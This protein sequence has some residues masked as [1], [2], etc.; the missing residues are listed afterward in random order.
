[1]ATRSTINPRGTSG[2][3]S[4]AGFLTFP[5]GDERRPAERRAPGLVPPSGHCARPFT[6][7][8][9]GGAGGSGRRRPMTCCAASSTSNI[10]STP[11]NRLFLNPKGGQR[12][13]PVPPAAAFGVWGGADA[14][15]QFAVE[16]CGAS[17]GCS[18]SSS[19]RST[20]GNPMGRPS[21][22]NDEK[23]WARG[24]GHESA[25]FLRTQWRQRRDDGPHRGRGVH[26]RCDRST[27]TPGRHP[28]RPADLRDRPSRRSA[29]AEFVIL[30]IFQNTAEAQ[31]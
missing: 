19:I 4:Y 24:Q 12:H 1:M 9:D 22:P 7:A 16:I 21:K 29:P 17:G 3:T 2:D 18:S 5:W 31:S 20:E 27:M 14:L 30:R 13:P 11:T 6:P 26:H 8:T 28:E 25:C 10:R 15:L 23:L